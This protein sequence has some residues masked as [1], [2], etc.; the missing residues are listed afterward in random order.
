MIG[1]AKSDFEGEQ[2]RHIMDTIDTH[3]ATLILVL[4]VMLPIYGLQL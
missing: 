2:F 1:Y 3:R 4:T